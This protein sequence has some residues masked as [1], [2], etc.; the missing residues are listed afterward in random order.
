MNR[1]RADAVRAVLATVDR[2]GVV[3]DADAAEASI[4]GR[5]KA[6]ISPGLSL[7][8]KCQSIQCESTNTKPRIL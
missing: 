5:R 6:M 3:G 7:R 1:G 4:K 2:K 8:E